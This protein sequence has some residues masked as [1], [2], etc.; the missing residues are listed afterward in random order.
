MKLCSCAELLAY[1]E[2]R[3]DAKE[4]ERRAFNTVQAGHLRDLLETEISELKAIMEKVQEMT[5]PQQ[6]RRRA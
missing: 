2:A 1:L 6:T 5:R 3:M 4:N